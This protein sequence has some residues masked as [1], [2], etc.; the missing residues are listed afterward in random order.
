MAAHSQSVS[1]VAHDFAKPD[2]CGNSLGATIRIKLTR[3]FA[4]AVV[5]SGPQF[6]Q[7]RLSRDSNMSAIGGRAE[8]YGLRSK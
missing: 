8:V 6:L 3:H 5:L 2:N 7:R 4:R 1:F